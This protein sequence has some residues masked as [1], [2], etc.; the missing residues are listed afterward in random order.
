[1]GG[2]EAIAHESEM[3]KKI[4]LDEM[5]RSRSCVQISMPV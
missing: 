1:M 2:H 3:V 5:S 4:K